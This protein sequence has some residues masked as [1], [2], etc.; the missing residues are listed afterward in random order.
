[1]SYIDQNKARNIAGQVI[2]IIQK[3]S[4]GFKKTRTS[5]SLRALFSPLTKLHVV[6]V[7]HRHMS[8]SSL[9]FVHLSLS[10][11]PIFHWFWALFFVQLISLNFL[12][13]TDAS[14]ISLL[15]M[16]CFLLWM[17]HRPLV[18]S[19]GTPWLWTFEIMIMKY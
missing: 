10:L 18:I 8:L 9:T 7:I 11:N 4:S 2:I 5:L 19:W 12:T 16:I 14:C 6:T 15:W 17:M 1:M 13:L 3:L